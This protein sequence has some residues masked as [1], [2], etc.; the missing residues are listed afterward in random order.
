[1]PRD[2]NTPLP[3]ELKSAENNELKSAENKESLKIP[4]IY[5][6]GSMCVVTC[7]NPRHRRSSLLQ[8]MGNFPLKYFI[9]LIEHRVT[10]TL[11]LVLFSET[12][13]NPK[14]NHWSMRTKR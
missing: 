9:K 13:T 4:A 14:K 8:Q 5:T 6:S 10:T 1:M 3:S 11:N 7:A 12:C 2:R